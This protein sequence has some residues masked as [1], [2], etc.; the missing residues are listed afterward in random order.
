MKNYFILISLLFGGTLLVQAQTPKFGHIN[1]EELVSLMPA[2]D[3][4]VVKIQKFA[5]ELQNMYDD[6]ETEY[7]LKMNEFQQKNASWS[8]AILETKQ[9]EVVEL[10]QR[11]QQFSQSAGQ[12]LQNTQSALLT[13]VYSEANEAVKKIAKELNLIYVFDSPGMP[14]IDEEQSVNLMDRAKAALKIPAE[15]VAPSMIGQ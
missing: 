1:L 13:P 5:M 3:S 15:K 10:S 6:I 11:L 2:R 12:D 8:A 9:R 14:Y 7:N 4:A